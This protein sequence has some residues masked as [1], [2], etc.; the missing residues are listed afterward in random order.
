MSESERSSHPKQA[1]KLSDVVRQIRVPTAP[2]TLSADEPF[3]GLQDITTMDGKLASLSKVSDVRSSVYEFDAGDVLYGR[4]RPNLRK[5]AVAPSPGYASGEVIVLRCAEELRPRFLLTVLLSDAFAN[6]ATSRATGDRPRVSFRAIGEFR[7]SLPGLDEQDEIVARDIRVGDALASIADVTAS[8]EQLAQTLTQRM[9]SLHIWTPRV[10]TDLV[11]FGELVES[12]DYGTTRRSEYG[13]DGT[14]VLRIP[15]IGSCGEIDGEGLKYA[16]LD[17]SE[18]NRTRLSVDDL[19]I[20]RSNGSLALVGRAARVREEFVGFSFA[21]YLLRA[22]PRSGIDAAY[23]LHVIQSAEFR[24]M[25]ESAVQSSTGIHNLSA[26]RLAEFVVPV[27][28]IEQQREAVSKLDRTLAGTSE[29]VASLRRLKEFATKAQSSARSSWLGMT[30]G[31]SGDSGNIRRSAG[32]VRVALQLSGG[33]TG[34]L[35]RGLERGASDMLGSEDSTSRV[36]TKGGMVAVSVLAVMA[37]YESWVSGQD[38]FTHWLAGRRVAP[39][40]IERFYDEL[41]DLER[42][43]RVE[44][45]PIHDESG[46]K[47]GDEMRCVPTEL[48]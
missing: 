34:A 11:R 9:R 4:M 17:I 25:V 6:Y 24:A 35:R 37:G 36:S 21:G 15:N 27:M 29:A 43:G 30:P 16:P 48:P 40:L 22:R 5:V 26:G 19:L 45:R 18:A 46:R 12:I 44:S 41:V 3:V 7:F 2:R 28:P 14:P 31:S 39:D 32:A 13:A 23:L 1:I 10:G 8:A 47:I 38:L 20:V 33:G 42:E